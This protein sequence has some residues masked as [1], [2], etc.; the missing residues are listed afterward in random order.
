MAKICF[1]HKGSTGGG[2]P[3]T[4]IY[5]TAAELQK[6]GH[7]VTYDKP[8]NA[9]A[10]IAIITTGKFLRYCKNSKTKIILRIDGV[11]Q[12]E[13][14]RLFNRAIRP[15]MKALHDKLLTDIPGVDH[16]V[17]QSQWS[18]DSIDNE[19]VVR[20]DNNWSIIHNGV[21]TNIFKPIPRKADGFTNLLH[22]GKMRDKYL[23]E[24]IIGCHNIMRKRDHK[25]RL[26]LVGSM[27]GPCNKIYSQFKNDPNIRH[28]GSIKN[29]KLAS[30][31]GQGDIF[32]GPRIGSSSDNVIPE[33]QACGLPVVVPSFGGNGEMIRDGVTGIV[34]PSGHWDYGAKYRY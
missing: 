32:I 34:V 21:N 12:A 3:V 17:Y 19:I 4:F 22:C 27:D 8:Q 2:G 15:D 10:A 26:I 28:L 20:K 30:A 6:R 14:N 9:D 16:V 24:A 7:I 11:Y 18:K 29:T 5:K 13:Y 33:A 1:N 31:Y 23:M 25:V